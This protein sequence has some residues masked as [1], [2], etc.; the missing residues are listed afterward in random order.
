MSKYKGYSDISKQQKL[1]KYISSIE[2]ENKRLKEK[3]LEYQNERYIVS[4]LY[5]NKDKATNTYAKAWNMMLEDANSIK[6]LDV[7]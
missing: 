6:E 5:L 4:K 2:K 7:F 3:E 1:N